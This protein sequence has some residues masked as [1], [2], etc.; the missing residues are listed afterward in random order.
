MYHARS[1]VPH[2][3]S[4][5]GRE[6]R[7]VY[8]ARGGVT[9]DVSDPLAQPHKRL[10]YLALAVADGG[11]LAG[12]SANARIL[13][14]RHKAGAQHEAASLERRSGVIIVPRGH[15]EHCGARCMH[16][17]RP[18]VAEILAE[19]GGIASNLADSGPTLSRTSCQL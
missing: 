19:S 4:D 6:R 13:R 15:L 1:R 3:A 8:R 5:V 7:R 9:R 18:E 14:T 10:V 12:R 11:H 17:D 2:G 16:R